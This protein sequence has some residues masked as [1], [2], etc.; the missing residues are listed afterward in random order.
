MSGRPPNASGTSGEGRTGAPGLRLEILKELQLLI[1]NREARDRIDR[2]PLA[3]AKGREHWVLHLLLRAHESEQAHLD[4]LVGSVYGNLTARLQSL[5]D[6]LATLSESEG[7]AQTEVVGRLDALGSVVSDKLEQGLKGGVERISAAST[8]QIAK[9]LDERWKPIGESIET[10]A[11]GSKQMLK[12]VSDTY[13]VATQTRLLMNENARRISD[14]GRDIVALEETLKLVVQRTLEE[15]FAGLEQRVAQLE[16]H[17]GIPSPPP[18]PP[19]ASAPEITDPE[20]PTDAG[21]GS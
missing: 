19:A 13:K 12:D 1:D 14:L 9:E 4:R 6:R 15:G 7:S 11:Q 10:F 18:T 3:E 17:A 16:A 2:G 20:K 21:A 8:A 5:E